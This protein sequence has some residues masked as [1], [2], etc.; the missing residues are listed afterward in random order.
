MKQIRSMSDF[1]RIF[2]TVL[3]GFTLLLLTVCVFIPE[4][5][6]KVIYVTGARH[7]FLI[8]SKKSNNAYTHLQK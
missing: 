2:S 4:R 1:R 3:V 6:A 7:N 5:E 8:M